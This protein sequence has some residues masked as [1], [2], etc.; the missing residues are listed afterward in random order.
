MDIMLGVVSKVEDPNKFIIRFKVKGWL[1]DCIAYPIDTDDQ[2]Q[3]DDPVVLFGLENVFGY[4]WM[5]KKQRLLDYTQLKHTNSVINIKKDTIIIQSGKSNIE[6]TKDG[7]VTIDAPD[8]TIT[9]GTLTTKGS[10]TADPTGDGGFNSIKYCPYTG[11]P[12]VG[13]KVSGT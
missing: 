11:A 13:N 1:E 9:G 7:K 6:L 2:P 3:V 5:Y 12:H 4:S 10:V 8:V